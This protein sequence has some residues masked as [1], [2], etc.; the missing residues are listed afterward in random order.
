MK[1]ALPVILITLL[2]FSYTGLA[3]AQTASKQF[4]HETDEIKFHGS[5]TVTVEQGNQYGTAFAAGLNGVRGSVVYKRDTLVTEIV[6]EPVPGKEREFVK[7]LVEGLGL[8]PA[9]ADKA[10]SIVYRYV[11]V[12]QYYTN[13]AIVPTEARTG[14]VMG[15]S[16]I[17]LLSD[18]VAGAGYLKG[19]QVAAQMAEWNKDNL[20]IGEL[21]ASIQYERDRPAR[22]KQ[23]RKE[24][25]KAEKE[26][27]KRD[28][29]EA[30]RKAKEE[31][32]KTSPKTQ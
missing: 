22:E 8:A 31:S 7:L 29:D 20:G 6:A 9:V 15:Q 1:I 2:V 26:K 21:Y 28:R 5:I 24:R 14:S 18:F 19:G 23:E 25:E 3:S 27:A 11:R 13:D 12:D 10:T 32:K 4:N 17:V 30:K 16:G